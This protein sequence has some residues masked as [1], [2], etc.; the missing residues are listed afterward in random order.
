MERNRDKWS[1]HKGFI[2]FFSNEQKNGK[3]NLLIANTVKGKGFS[4]LRKQ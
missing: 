1:Q 4:L 3:P 2:K